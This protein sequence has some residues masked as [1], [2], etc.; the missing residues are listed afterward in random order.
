VIPRRVTVVRPLFRAAGLLACAVLAGV[1]WA[2]G[3][4][5]E[6]LVVV[7][8][9]DVPV[10]HVTPEDV[11]RIYRGQ[12]KA[13]GGTATSPVDYGPE[14]GFRDKFLK[15]VVGTDAH[16]FTAYWL[17]EVYLNGR[18]PPERAVSPADALER[19]TRHPGT[20]AYVR[21]A[22]IAGAAGERVRVVLELPCPKNRPKDGRG[23]DN[24]ATDPVGEAGTVT[25][26]RTA[27]AD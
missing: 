6:D 18:L 14:V 22:D 9:R 3:A 8:S 19:V 23:R 11:G 12:L 21:P 2:T 26:I 20:V 25:P 4:A 5:A 15:R 7:V 16:Q 27:R 17:K 10:E 1:P 13:L 24:G